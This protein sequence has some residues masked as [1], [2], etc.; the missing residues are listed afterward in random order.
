VDRRIRIL[1][2]VVVVVALAYPA[3]AWLL[4]MSVEHQ[5]HERERLVVERVP[6]IEIVKSDYRRGVYS[7]T[8]EVTYALGGPMLRSMPAAGTLNWSAHAQ[9][10]VRNTVHHGPLPQLRTFAPAT[11]DTEVILPADLPKN[12]ALALDTSK[13]T[14]TIHTRMNWLGGSTT[15]VKSQAFHTKVQDDREIDWRGL[16]ASIEL[17][18]QF[19]TESIDL[20]APGLHLQGPQSNVSFEN[21]AIKLDTQTAFD[22]VTAGT[23]HLTLGR[24]DV[25]HSAQD[26]KATLQNLAFDSKTSV[27]GDYMNSAG[28]IG[29]DALQAGKFAATRLFY[30][31]HLDHLHGPSLAA[32]TKALRIVPKDASTNATPADYTKQFTEAFRTYGADIMAHEPVLDM[33][34]IGFTTPDGELL[35]SVKAAAPGIT[36]A[37]FDVAPQLLGAALAQH[38][39]LSVDVRIDTALLDKLL[40]STGKGDTIAAQM[41]GLQRQGY[42]KLDGKALTTH[43]TF[44]SGRIKVNDLP[45]PPMPAAGPGPGGPGTPGGPGAPGAPGVPSP[46]AR[47]RTPH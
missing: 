7:S 25:E 22:P 40:D 35:I 26:F 39:Q 23:A 27:S 32:M 3:A 1:L 43:L 17:G 46:P 21:L 44:Q 10:T 13:G 2:I 24:F 19:G 29:I 16:D 14:L 37:D 38:A 47:P 33:P 11:V 12:L 34:R 31:Q 42:L 5:W 36:R 4:G 6:Y 30:E 41:Q 45:F 15:L 28:T 8:E 20:R 9:F 18:R